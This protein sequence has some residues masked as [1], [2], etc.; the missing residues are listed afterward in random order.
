MGNFEFSTCVVELGFVYCLDKEGN[1]YK[2][3]L[4]EKVSVSECPECAIKAL[5][6]VKTR[7]HVC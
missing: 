5:L 1:I 6:A 3:P 7:G 2:M 4:P